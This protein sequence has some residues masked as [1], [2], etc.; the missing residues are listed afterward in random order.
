MKTRK[1][2]LK[3]T[4]LK[5]LAAL[6]ALTL[7]LS[8]FAA[9]KPKETDDPE[10]MGSTEPTDG[11]NRGWN[12]VIPMQDDTTQPFTTEPAS[13]TEEPPRVLSTE[14]LRAIAGAVV[15]DARKG[16]SRPAGAPVWDGDLASLTEEE[17]ALVE[18]K[19][20]E[21]TGV[22]LS[23]AGDGSVKYPPATQPSF[24]YTTNP[25]SGNTQPGGG[26]P[27]GSGSGGNNPIGG[28]P[29]DSVNPPVK[30]T[31]GSGNLSLADPTSPPAN[32]GPVLVGAQKLKLNTFGTASGHQRYKASAATANG[33]FVVAAL[34]DDTPPGAPAIN[35]SYYQTAI[36][37]YSPEGAVEWTKYFGGNAT[38][39]MTAIAV[40]KDGSIVAAGRTAAT[41]LEC[42]THTGTDHDAILLKLTGSGEKV[43]MKSYQGS[44]WEEFSCIAATPDG[45]F[46]VGGYTKSADGDFEGLSDT[47]LQVGGGGTFERE[48][49]KSI[50][51]KMDKDGV[52]YHKRVLQGT[53]DNS[54]TALAADPSNGDVYAAVTTAA[55]DYDFANIVG[56]GMTDTLMIRFSKTFEA[57]W[58]KPFAGND[59]E[60]INALAAAP[61]GGVVAVGFI[62]Y[63]SYTTGSF[64][65]LSSSGFGRRGGKDGVALKY[66]RDGSVAWIRTL[67]DVT[68]DEATCVAAVEGGY[69]VAGNT[70]KP[71]ATQSFKYD[72]MSYPFGGG[73]LDSWF[74]LL[75]ED[76][77]QAKFFPIQGAG[78][79]CSYGAAAKGRGF[80]V[81]GSTPSSDGYF[82]GISPASGS[83][84]GGHVAFLALYQAQYLG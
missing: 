59:R 75:R 44:R 58:M 83:A 24:V 38:F 41:N 50:V 33:G 36:I 82:A 47:L 68:D 70:L 48:A 3:G 12:P 27:S 22:D 52:V 7:A 51:L 84:T 1:Q 62:C 57:L 72:F 32:P 71:L 21:D 23:I 31:V 81:V 14:E 67:G 80:A 29:G 63:S 73:D 54:F 13:T 17:R 16:Q 64:A 9:C 5:V 15:E 20:K 37:Q 78:M 35:G 2:P 77:S 61:D 79:D 19:V 46:V 40:L 11:T 39:E 43:W 26:S 34:V 45:G 53:K 65:G 18:Q 8:L 56:Y 6:L 25:G 74:W 49:I 4:I 30:E 69:V 76:G 55:D 66:N 10:T 60:F 28:T 42:P